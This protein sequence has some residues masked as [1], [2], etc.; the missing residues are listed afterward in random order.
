[1][2]IKYEL[3]WDYYDGP[4]W[5]LLCLYTGSG[6][7]THTDGIWTQPC[8]HHNHPPHAPFLLKIVKNFSGKKAQLFSVGLP[9][10]R[11]KISLFLSL[12]SNPMWGTNRD[13]SSACMPWM[14]EFMYFSLWRLGGLLCMMSEVTWNIFVVTIPGGRCGCVCVTVCLC[15]WGN[16]VCGVYI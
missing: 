11:V 3:Q 12:K 5:V 8:T 1:M 16:L 7:H 9:S 10:S 15:L 6:T 2:K 4:G 14:K 13:H